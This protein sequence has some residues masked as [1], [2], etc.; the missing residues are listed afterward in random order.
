M[1]ELRQALSGA[2]SRELDR[3]ITRQTTDKSRAERIQAA[4]D[5]LPCIED[6][7]RELVQA[8]LG[9]Y[10]RRIAEQPPLPPLPPLHRELWDIS[11]QLQRIVKEADAVVEQIPEREPHWSE[12]MDQLKEGSRVFRVLMERVIV[13]DMD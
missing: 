7:D 5:R 13:R 4:I 6:G 12:I 8:A 2:Y 3:I 9:E 11:D 1:N 10:R